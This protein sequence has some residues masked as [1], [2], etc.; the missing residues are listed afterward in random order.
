LVVAGGTGGLAAEAEVGRTAQLS[1]WPAWPTEPCAARSSSSH[2]LT[3]RA[4]AL[5]PGQSG[6]RSQRRRRPRLRCASSPRVRVAVRQHS[7]GVSWSA[8]ESLSAIARDSH[9]SRAA[10]SAWS[11]TRPSSVIV[12]RAR[13]RSSGSGR[14]VTNPSASRSAT[15]RGAATTTPRSQTAD[16]SGVSLR[17]GTIPR[18][19]REAAGALRSTIRQH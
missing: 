14:R 16:S 13:R 8:G 18:P 11:L 3:P 15:M 6:T 10:R 2:D 12:T 9:P 17:S 4:G 19:A 1:A 5:R 7:R